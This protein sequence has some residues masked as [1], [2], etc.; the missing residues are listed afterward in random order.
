M[1]WLSVNLNKNQERN[2]YTCLP[3]VPDYGLVLTQELKLNQSMREELVARAL[4][5]LNLP[6]NKLAFWS[7]LFKF[8]NLQKEMMPYLMHDV[9][10]MLW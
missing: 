1:Y 8:D 10:Q 9:S 4:S 5:E 2:S 3:F 7:E 6:E